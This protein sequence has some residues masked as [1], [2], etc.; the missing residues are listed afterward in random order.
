MKL[1][2]QLFAS[3]N[4]GDTYE[5][6]PIDIKPYGY[7]ANHYQMKFT[8]KL[9]SQNLSNF[10]SNI[11]ITS[12][13]R[14]TGASWGW[15]GFSKIYMERYTKAN[16]EAGYT[17]R[18][19]TQIKSLPTNNANVWVNCGSW[20]GDIQH[21]SNGTCTLYVKNHLLTSTSSSYSYIPRDTEQESEALTLHQLHTAPS[22]N[23]SSITET[24]TYL[25]VSNDVFVQNLSRKSYAFTPILY[26]S[27]TATNVTISNGSTT[28]NTNT[29]SPK[30]LDFTNKTLYT[31]ANV[32]PIK[33]VIKD[34]L[35]STGE[36]LINYSASTKCIF[37]TKPTINTSTSVKRNGQLSGKVL[38][39]LYATYYNGTIGSTTNTITVQYKFWEKDT[40]EPSSWNDINNPTISG[41]NI[42][43]SNYE[44]GSNN[45]SASNYFNPQKAYNVKIY[46]KDA[47]RNYSGTYMGDTITKTIPLGEDVWGEYK[48]RLRIKK[49]EVSTD[50][51][52]P[53][54]DLFNDTSG[55]D[56]KT[57]LKNKIDYCISNI[58]TSKQNM[59]TFINGGWS[60]VNY[61]FG[62]FSKIGA[63]YQLTWFTN[64]GYKYVRKLNSTY[65]YYSSIPDTLYNNDTGIQS[66]YS[67]LIDNLSSYKKL[68]I[69]FTV[70]KNSNNANTG[71]TAHICWLDLTK[72]DTNNYA[73]SGI[74]VPYSSAHLVDGNI[75]PN[76]F[77]ALFEANL[78]NNRVYC[79]FGY[80][81]SVQTN[82]MYVMT[83]IE[84]YYN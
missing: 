65:S 79:L 12:Y 59:E 14:T 30:I 8:V 31:S 20:S 36:V 26:D 37:Y 83:K 10:T 17:L 58:N 34:S 54:L 63:V 22:L 72:K 41:N 56:W 13:M 60:G 67:A 29:T 28:S 61:G 7:N 11:T 73:R 1:N 44:I 84:G 16:D 47:M 21:K 18:N 5:T 33:A 43:V 53:N 50:I 9:N 51:I 38:L 24:N 4:V 71:G 78:N 74:I 52:N 76:D 6:T 64:D 62:I 15:S 80:N 23:I 57:M 42:T 75:Q 68:A 49:V 39:N 46:I 40:T 2:I 77:K 82:A 69:T 35:N 48:D 70:Y 55:S 25:G 3:L 66:K 32:L 81:G 19:N 45:T 27:A